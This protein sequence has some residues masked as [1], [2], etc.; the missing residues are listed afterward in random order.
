MLTRTRWLG[1]DAT[2]METYKRKVSS[3]LT[4]VFTWSSCAGTGLLFGSSVHVDTELVHKT[5]VRQ[6]HQVASLLERRENTN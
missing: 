6:A 2:D 5:E 3:W 1:P 4:V